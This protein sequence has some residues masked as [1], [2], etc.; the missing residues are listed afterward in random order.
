MRAHTF[1][2]M[3]LCLFI[4]LMLGCAGIRDLTKP[5]SPV[6]ML[7]YRVTAGGRTWKALNVET[8]MTG[9]CTFTDE[10]TGQP[11]EIRGGVIVVE[12]VP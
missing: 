12:R 7:H 3:V 5:A 2:S 8:Y 11:V 6:P 9:S 10:E 1:I 4:V